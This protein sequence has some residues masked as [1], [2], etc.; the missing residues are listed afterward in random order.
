[1]FYD[2][3]KFIIKERKSKNDFINTTALVII[4][5]QLLTCNFQAI[6]AWIFMEQ[7]IT[8]AM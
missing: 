2:L 7:N 1:M 3:N 5:T 4:K 8:S 6:S